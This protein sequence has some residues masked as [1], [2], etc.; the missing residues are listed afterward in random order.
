MSG[1][2][3]AARR[4]KLKIFTIFLVF[5]TTFLQQ[6][7]TTDNI[8][9]ISVDCKYCIIVFLNFNISQIKFAAV[10][11]FWR[12]V[13]ESILKADRALHESNHF[14]TKVFHLN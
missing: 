11:Y 3:E 4:L 8:K 12:V 13:K 5:K 1:N 14:S 7:Y 9:A 6:I 2:F 10:C